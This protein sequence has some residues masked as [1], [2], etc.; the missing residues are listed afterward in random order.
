MSFFKSR[1]IIYYFFKK[2]VLSYLC[3]LHNFYYIEESWR[4]EAFLHLYSISKSLHKHFQSLTEVFADRKVIPVI[5]EDFE[6]VTEAP[7]PTVEEINQDDE[8][9][10]EIISKAEFE[11]VY[12]CTEYTEKLEM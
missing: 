12:N 7:I 9:F 3:S 4:Y 5:Y 8:F 6:F 10:A 2:T 1:Y 11:K